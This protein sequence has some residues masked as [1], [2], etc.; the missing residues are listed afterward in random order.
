MALFDPA[1]PGELIRETIEGIKKETGEKLT[2]A[3]VAEGLG[4]T[5]KT[6][7]AI[8]NGRQ[9]VTPE[10]ALRLEKAFTNATAEFWLQVQESYNLAIARQKVDTKNVRVFWQ[11]PT[12][13]TSVKLH[14]LTPQKSHLQGSSKASST[15]P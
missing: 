3:E 15:S 8:I 1:H 9:S 5:R 4:T 6:L 11:P 10:M 12:L 14:L 13:P 2:V 7:S